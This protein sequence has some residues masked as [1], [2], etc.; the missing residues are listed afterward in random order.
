[1]FNI[2]Q[3]NEIQILMFGLILLRMTAFVVSSAIFSS[4]SI[5]VMVKVLFS[6][7]LTIVVFNSVA[8]SE[9]LVRLHDLENSLMVLAARELA[10]GLVLGFVTRLFFFALSMAGELV[11]VSLGLG[12]AQMF[13]PMMGSMGNAMEQ[14]YVIIGTLVYLSLDGHH[15]MIQGLVQSFQVSKVALMSFN[16]E[17][18]AEIT[19]K[20]QSFFVL[21]IKIAAPILISMIVIQVGIAL[22]SRAVPQINVLVTS[23]SIT[24]LIGFIVI[25]ISLPLL[26]MQMTGL[27][28]LTHVE[29]FKFLKTL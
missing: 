9:A 3:L 6:V 12:Q 22:V 21:G 19:M 18:F 4:P 8:T 17:S 26:V 15:F 29:F 27:M 13:N 10:I 5:S 25:F 23:A 2:S 11:S 7:V 14:F 16:Y 28:N 20:A 24:S 1:M